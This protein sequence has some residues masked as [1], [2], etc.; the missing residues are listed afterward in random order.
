MLCFSNKE[1]LL[2][3]WP[4]EAWEPVE[5]SCSKLRIQSHSGFQ[6][7]LLHCGGPGYSPTN[8]SKPWFPGS[9]NGD[10]NTFIIGLMKITWDNAQEVLQFVSSLTVSRLSR[11]LYE[12]KKGRRFH[13]AGKEWELNSIIASCRDIFDLETNYLS[14]AMAVMYGWQPWSCLTRGAEAH[15]WYRHTVAKKHIHVHL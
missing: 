7:P 5:W 11:R 1:M 12:G 13:D 4:K 14:P 2:I 3:P 8:H 15:Q 9:Y 10:N 6:P